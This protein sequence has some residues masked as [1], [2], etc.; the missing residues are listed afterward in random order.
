MSNNSWATPQSPPDESIETALQFAPNR[1]SNDRQVAAAALKYHL[2]GNEKFRTT[3]NHR[4][5]SIVTPNESPSHLQRYKYHGKQHVA[6]VVAR[7]LIQPSPS[8]TNTM[9][10][11]ALQYC[12]REDRNNFERIFLLMLSSQQPLLPSH[13]SSNIWEH[14]LKL[15]TQKPQFLHKILDGLNELVQAGQV[16]GAKVYRWVLPHVIKRRATE[17]QN[18][19]I[20]YWTSTLL[21]GRFH[22]DN[23][24]RDDTFRS[25]CSLT[26]TVSTIMNVRA[27]FG[28]KGIKIKIHDIVVRELCRQKKFEDAHQLH[29]LL[30]TRGDLPLSSRSIED[31]L[32]YH[33]RYSERTRTQKFIDNLLLRDIK[34]EVGVKTLIGS[35]LGATNQMGAVRRNS[36]ALFTP[37]QSYQLDRFW[38]ATISG[39]SKAGHDTT[40]IVELMLARSKTIGKSAMESCISISRTLESVNVLLERSLESGIDISHRG[41]AKLIRY[42]AKQ[43]NFSRAHDM[44]QECL[45]AANE[46]NLTIDVVDLFRESM[47]LGL[48]EGEHYQELEMRHRAMCLAETATSR[49]WNLLL[50]S[51]LADYQV[52]G[53]LRGLEEMRT[54]GLMV[55]NSTA[56]DLLA[57]LLRK[58]RP[59]RNPDVLDSSDRRA[60]LADI[61]AAI[62]IAQKCLKLGGRTQ[63][64]TWQE[65]AK[66]L[67]RYGEFESLERLTVWLIRQYSTTTEQQQSDSQRYFVPSEMQ[68]VLPPDHPQHPL[69][70]LIPPREVAATITRGFETRRPARALS[71]VIKWQQMGVAVDRSAVKKRIEKGIQYSLLHSPTKEEAI[72]KLADRLMK[73]LDQLN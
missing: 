58:R 50:R 59:F 18:I 11:C 60:Y 52:D 36:E 47:L 23:A 15:G 39:A 53:A 5:P 8:C 14:A 13:Y 43:G 41:Y 7:D 46:E 64:E 42:R 25:L 32:A 65:I 35:F 26:P 21:L 56:R 9:W 37:E 4:G 40:P 6:H 38:S 72:N 51:R 62:V 24:D 71:L 1:L 55:E 2:S 54:Q 22:P 3:K 48:L 57:A 44:L 33:L 34:L 68:M 63:P 20:E 73:R 17:C 67:G 28:R 45:K 27:Q 16:T 66:R 31:L 49:T 19:N 10:W 30:S 61:Q 29:A 12:L 69:S 70:R